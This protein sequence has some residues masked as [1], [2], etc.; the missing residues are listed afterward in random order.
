MGGHPYPGRRGGGGACGELVSLAGSAAAP[1]AWCGRFAVPAGA[2]HPPEPSAPSS[3]CR[4]LLWVALPSWRSARRAKPEGGVPRFGAGGYS[5]GAV[6]VPLVCPRTLLRCP[7]PGCLNRLSGLRWEG[8]LQGIPSGV[9]FAAFCTRKTGGIWQELAA[10]VASFGLD[11]SY[12]FVV[13]LCCWNTKSELCVCSVVRAV[14]S[15][16]G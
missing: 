7:R 6:A 8:L 14:R 4:S 16:V 15:G 3:A 5:V 11:L 10:V 12:F 2:G 1:P 13:L 9:A